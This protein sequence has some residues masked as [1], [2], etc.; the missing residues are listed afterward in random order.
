MKILF[1]FKQFLFSR[2]DKSYSAIW[3]KSLNIFKNE[4]NK[5]RLKKLLID[6]ESNIPRHTENVE[7]DKEWLKGTHACDPQTLEHVV[8]KK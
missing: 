3:I 8:S 6:I 5:T 7:A 4:D 2:T 1:Y